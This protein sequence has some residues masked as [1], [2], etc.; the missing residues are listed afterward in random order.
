M[1]SNRPLI[2]AF[3]ALLAI[4]VCGCVAVTAFFGVSFQDR[5]ADS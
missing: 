5:F 4:A 2:I 1:K 3:G